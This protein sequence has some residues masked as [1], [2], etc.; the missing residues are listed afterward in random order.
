MLELYHSLVSP[1]A[2]KVRLVLHE[3]GLEYRSQVLNIVA[4]ENLKPEYL[5]LNPQGVVPTLL[6]DGL[7]VVESTFICEYLDEAFPDTPM[8]RGDIH[9]RLR[10]RLWMKT[11][12]EKLHPALGA[13]AWAI[14]MR[15][16]FLERGEAAAVEAINKVPDPARRSRQLRILAQGF[17]ASDVADAIAVY[18]DM[19]GKA[20]RLLAQQQWVS[21][22]YFGLADAA[23]TPYVHALY[24]YSIQDV[25]ISPGGN[26][27]RWF[28]EVAN[29]AAFEAAVVAWV[30]EARLKML[31][32]HGR[33]CHQELSALAAT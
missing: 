9:E 3:K 17:A 16:Q 28:T 18:R 27:E 33:D 31:A 1:C 22:S 25:F 8:L 15:R 5:K 12:D 4:K 32:G 21:G 7:P 30:P 11:I 24:Q 20:E 14:S 19:L 6:H 2:Q 26:V 13:L 23:L 29:R 10:C